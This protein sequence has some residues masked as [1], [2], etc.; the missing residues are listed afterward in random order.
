MTLDHLPRF[1]L[2]SLP[3]P[4]HPLERL[5]LLLGGPLVLVKRDDLTGLA[6]GGN[7]TRKLEFLI[8][9]ALAGGADTVITAGATQ[10]NHCRQTAAAAARAGLQCHLV[11]GGS[12]PEAPTGN[13]LLD[14]LL[15]A[16]VH[17]AGPDR[18]GETMTDVAVELRGRGRK[19]YVIP[20]GGSNEVGATG[21]VVAMGEFC[22][23][24]AEREQTVDLIVFATSSG[25][26]Q[27]GLVVGARA[28]GFSGQILGISV[29]K[30]ERGAPTYERELTALA[31]AT[32]ERIGL[33]AR[34]GED[35]F[36]VDYDYVGD[37]YGILMERERDAIGL[38]A[39][40]EGMLLDPVYTG[41][42]MGALMDMIRRGLIG[43][44]KTVLF[45]HTGGGPALFAYA[46][47]L[48]G[49][50]TRHNGART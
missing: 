6:L 41:K 9:D 2:A 21:Y 24:M 1:P 49:G 28:F 44:S 31:A 4:V 23:Q 17:W 19:V 30:V 33:G 42:A 48:T 12:P 38:M 7:K 46:E 50:I 29:D 25:G 43:P 20:Y 36:W 13:L 47:G 14:G 10:S 45:W 15:G 32:S 5:S 18:R 39:R 35:D 40:T 11:L 22:R 26:T 27:A 16:S 8:G 3:T 34:H 37:G